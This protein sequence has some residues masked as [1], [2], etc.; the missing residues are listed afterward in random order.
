MRFT[1]SPLRGTA[2]AVILSTLLLAGC[3]ATSGTRH[4]QPPPT[5]A[6]ASVTLLTAHGIP[7]TYLTDSSGRALYMWDADRNGAST[8]YDAC[9][10]DWPPL[11]VGGTATAGPGVQASLIGSTEREDGTKQVTYGGWPLYYFLPDDQPGELSGQ[12]DTGFGAVWWVI[13]PGGKP[14]PSE[15]LA[16]TG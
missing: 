1:R 4:S 12:G 8:C 9:A 5:T 2:A 3:S 6:P 15:P 16:T 13:S 7:G 10:V 11:T 14:L